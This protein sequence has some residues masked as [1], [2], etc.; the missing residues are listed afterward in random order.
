M[1]VIH[2]DLLLVDILEN[3]N[4]GKVYHTLKYI[5][6]NIL[7]QHK[8]PTFIKTDE[9]TYIHLPN[10]A[11]W[12]QQEAAFHELNVFFGFSHARHNV[13]C[14]H[15]FT[16]AMYG[17]SSNLVSELVAKTEVKYRHGTHE[18]WATGTWVQLYGTN[19]TEISTTLGEL[20]MGGE[21]NMAAIDQ[22]VATKPGT[23]FIHRAKELD[24]WLYI[25]YAMANKSYMNV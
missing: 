23:I 25:Y 15:Y 5:A 20:D 11:A 6:D 21:Q 3:M 7:P 8:Y 12:M 19:V 18:D 22:Q 14:T 24:V 16:G 10:L 9:D 1:Q 4:Q 17:M 2:G 13:C